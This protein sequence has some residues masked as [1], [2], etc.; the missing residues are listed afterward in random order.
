[1]MKQTRRR[2]VQGTAGAALAF[3]VTDTAPASVQAADR[4]LTV[5]SW[6][7]TFA[8]AMREAVWQPFTK[9]SGI[10]I[11]EDTWN[12]EISKIKAMVDAKNVTWDL[13]TSDV[14]SAVRGCEEGFLLPIDATK[15]GDASDYYPGTTQ[16]CGAFID[17]VATV[18][19]YDGGN[20][21][22]A[23]RG[24]T[25]TKAIDIWDLTKFP[26][27]RGFRKHPKRTIEVALVADGVESNDI[28]KVLS[29]PG[30]IN[31]ALAKLDQ[32][33]S[34]IHFW[35]TN[36][37]PAQLLASGEVVLTQAF[38]GRIS[39]ANKNGGRKFTII[40]DHSIWGGDVL[41]MVK[42]PNA[43]KAMKLIS[44]HT[45]PEVLARV[46]RLLPYGPV[47]KSSMPLIEEAIAVQ[48]PT[49]PDNMKTAL[50][51]MNLNEGARWWADHEQEARAKFDTWLA[52]SP[53]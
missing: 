16:E 20:P 40:W 2:F 19:A 26:G 11:V 4:P 51:G 48:L 25:P 37:E 22:S 33:R 30:G 21:P 7:G 39:A 31:R 8:D 45:R 23:W 29:R 35:T 44:Y 46:A 42:G 43:D 14:D 36:D 6:G 9:E 24:A 50:T 15:I 41:I 32:I 53:R 3:G 49:Y 47:R 1:M 27:K 18:F 52:R 34:E 5:V 17:I 12:G 28:Y 13:I 10:P 38:N